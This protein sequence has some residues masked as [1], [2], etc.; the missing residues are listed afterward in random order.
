MNERLSHKELEKRLDELEKESAMY[1]EAE[2]ALRISEDRLR[3]LIEY[4][5]DSFIVSYY[6]DGKIIDVNQHACDSLGYTRGELLTMSV[7]DID[8]DFHMEKRESFIPSAP[9]TFERVLHRKD[10]TTF[11]GEIRLNIFESDGQKLMLGIIRDISDRR[12]IEKALG[13]AQKGMEEKIRARTM[14]LEEANRRL[15]EEVLE[16]EKAE[17]ILRIS[18]EKFS[19]A[20]HSS[21]NLM[22]ISTLKEG[23]FIDINETFLKVHGYTRDEVI[24][25]TSAELDLFP[26]LKD[27]EKIKNELLKKGSIHDFESTFR[28]K[29]GE[30][31]KGSFSAE[32]IKIDG[33]QCLLSVV[34]DITERKQA[35]DRL[36]DS[37]ERYRDLFEK[38]PVSMS[39]STLDGQLIAG[40]EAMAVVTGYTIDELK[41]I[42]LSELYKDPQTRKKLIQTINRDD[43]AFNFPVQLRRKDGRFSSLLMTAIKIHQAVGD[44]LLQ[45]IGVD[46]TERAQ[47][48]REK[49]RLGAQL[50]QSR[51]MDAIA[52]LAG[53]I[54]HQ[55]NNALSTIIG[56]LELLRMDSPDNKHIL[57]YIGPVKDSAYRMTHLT[58]QLLAYARGGKYQPKIISL[59]DL[60]RETLPLL[61]HTINPSINVETDL[62]S[63]I[64]FVIA[65]LT[66]MQMVMSAI[67]S[68]ASES[69]EGKGRIRISCRDEKIIGKDIKK[70][71][72]G[73]KPGTYVSM[74]IEDDGK[75]MDEKTKNRVFEPFFS[76]KFHGRGLEMAAVYGIINN[77]DGRISIDSEPGKGTRVH[78]YLPAVNVQVKKEEKPMTKLQKGTGT[79]LLIEDEETVMDVSHAMLERLGYRVLKAETGNKA[80]STA[81]NFEGKID[82]AILDVMLPDM[83]GKA[84]Y[85]LLMEARPDLKVIVC[86]GYSSDGPAQDILNAGAQ[87]FIQKPFSINTLSETLKEVLGKDSTNE[88][89][90][91]ATPL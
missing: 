47:V 9:I 5:T 31:R 39:L 35:E 52:A 85:P 79:I 89:V 6:D 51:K 62:P 69:I 14:E 16:R 19:K 7:A 72:A 23:R 27:R 8:Q 37:E 57:K 66:Q 75:G 83:N 28:V 2:E 78:V 54:A 48:E 45:I 34:D 60:V 49:D 1:R 59:N 70:K 53:G 32:I 33:R 84:I 15:R 30:I 90:M 61:K 56:N 29:S 82:L 26:D 25:H 20:F 24:G 38:S 77:H 76:T 58:D 65:D 43:I 11:T 4:S 12:Q 74:T 40:N 67:M 73:L 55:F 22:A 80:V 68:N 86:S 91:D 18:E 46:V 42:N 63:N 71:Y 87:Y 41:T 44:N 21:P 64:S 3:R 36:K 88:M 50:Q 17:E 13:R 81:K 10:G